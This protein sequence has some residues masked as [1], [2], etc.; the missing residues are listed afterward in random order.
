M[1][2]SSAP[3]ELEADYRDSEE[4]EEADE[5]IEGADCDV[6]S[7]GN[8]DEDDIEDDEAGEDE[9]AFDEGDG[10]EGDNGNSISE[11]SGADSDSD[12]EYAGKHGISGLLKV[13]RNL[14]FAINKLTVLYLGRNG[15]G[16][17]PRSCSPMTG[18][19]LM[20]ARRRQLRYVSLTVCPVPFLMD[21]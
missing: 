7:G 12:L 5:N 14:C 1:A 13:C 2:W 10:N 4:D 15:S 19:L 20:L 18:M 17:W 6:D 11:D 16:K 9:E 8:Q 21:L 3:A